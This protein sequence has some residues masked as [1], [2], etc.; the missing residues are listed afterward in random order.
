MARLMIFVLMA[1]SLTACGKVRDGLGGLGL[2]S[3]SPNRAQMIVDGVKYKAKAHTERSDRRA[4]TITITPAAGNPG[5]AQEAGRYEATRYCL[6]TYG[7]SDAEWTVG[8][9][10]PVDQLRVVDN[11][12]TLQGR[13]TQR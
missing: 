2:G 9:D 8:P 13:C 1:I 6:L 10:T 4:F 3:G 5:A 7:G 11:T 12:L